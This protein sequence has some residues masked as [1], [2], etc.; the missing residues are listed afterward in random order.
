MKNIAKY[1]MPIAI[2]GIV[3]VVIVAT[4]LYL[5]S[6]TPMEKMMQTFQQNSGLSSPLQENNNTQPKYFTLEEKEKM[7]EHASELQGIAGYINTEEGLTLQKLREENKVVIVDFWTFSCI[8]CQRTTPYLNSWYEKYKDQ[9][10]VIVGVHT[11]EFAFEKDYDNVVDATKRM[12]IMYPVVQDNDYKTWNAFGNRFWPRKYTIDTDGFIRYDHIGEGAY[13]QTE[14]VIQDLLAERA[15][16]LNLPLEM[17]KNVSKP[18]SAEDTDF[19]K[20]ETPEIYFGYNFLSGRNYIGNY[21]PASQENVYSFQIPA[22][23]SWKDNSAYLGGDWY[24][25]GDYMELR[26]DSGIVGLMFSAKK[27]NIVAGGNGTISVM[28]DGEK[29]NDLNKGSDVSSGIASV[30]GNRLYNLAS[31][32]SYGKHSLDLMIEG[33]VQIYTFTFG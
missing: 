31:L 18:E 5:I 6:I 20:I 29:V 3:I 8:N 2:I 11:P 1:K 32:D 23:D 30:N 9:G 28:L 16:K 33:D 15:Y 4:N 27:V 22:M 19:S 12:G 24:G 14:L 25:A 13:D 10:L 7:F 17:D 26:G 21:N